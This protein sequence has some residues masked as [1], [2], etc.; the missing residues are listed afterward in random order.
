MREL[1]LQRCGASE[2]VQGRVRGKA[3]KTA[4]ER[5]VRCERIVAEGCQ[6]LLW[7][8][9]TSSLLRPWRYAPAQ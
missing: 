6:L 1:N 7:V 2:R 5:C 4:G 3:V 8:R 9:G